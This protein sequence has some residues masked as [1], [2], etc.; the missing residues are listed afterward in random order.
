MTLNDLELQLFE[1]V[2]NIELGVPV[3][4]E[5]D[6]EGSVMKAIIIPDISP[7][8]HFELKYF[9]AIAGDSVA[10]GVGMEELFG[11][12]APLRKAWDQ[13][14]TVGVRLIVPESQFQRTTAPYLQTEVLHADPDH[15]GSLT[16]Q[17][18][19]VQKSTD[20]LISARFCIVGFPDFETPEKQWD[21]I[22]PAYSFG[23]P[24]LDLLRNNLGDGAKITVSP[25]SHFIVLE[26]PNGW[27]VTLTKDET[28]TRGE[29]SHTGVV[30]KQDG[31]AFSSTELK[32]ILN[33]LRDF[34]AFIAGAFCH[35][36]V[37]IG[38]DRNQERT[39]GQIGRYK[40]P[41]TRGNTW[42]RN[43]RNP[44]RGAFLEWLFRNFWAKWISKADEIADVI[45]SY[46]HSNAMRE[47]GVPNDALAP[48]HRR[49]ECRGVLKG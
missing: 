14:G 17:E 9:N 2:L 7:E 10:D 4:A 31:G 13:Q 33:A 44:S 29:V 23:L 37:V 30:E 38:Y 34:C 36:T 8:G 26:T 6:Y 35:P 28:P 47:V 27:K 42:F 43:N 45:E 49:Y 25:P 5:L 11:I 1:R 16:I 39:W 3:Q 46:V 12:D 20:P 15:R 19:Q 40:S 41:T 18:N 32:G 22:G 21:A 48:I 24:E